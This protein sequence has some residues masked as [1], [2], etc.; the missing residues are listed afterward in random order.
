MNNVII[1]PSLL[2]L[3]YSDVYEDKLRLLITFPDLPEI[4][5]LANKVIL[6]IYDER[7]IY[8]DGLTSLVE[9]G[10]FEISDA[11]SIDKIDITDDNKKLESIFL[12][13]ANAIALKVAQY[14]SVYRD[15]LQDN[16]IRSSDINHWNSS[17]YFNGIAIPSHKSLNSIESFDFEECAN[18]LVSQPLQ[19][20]MLPVN[21][22]AVSLSLKLNN[23][24]LPSIHDRLY[25]NIFSSLFNFGLYRIIQDFETRLIERFYSI[26]N[27]LDQ[28]RYPHFFQL[29][30]NNLD[31][32]VTLINQIIA[33]RSQFSPLRKRLSSFTENDI[34]RARLLK[35]IDE[36]VKRII[37][38]TSD[39]S[40]VKKL[41]LGVTEG[42]G[43]GLKE[44]N[45]FKF[46]FKSLRPLLDPVENFLTSKIN[47]NNIIDIAN[48]ISIAFSV[49][50][51]RALQHLEPI[52]KEQI[53]LNNKCLMLYQSN[54]HR[55][56]E[57]SPRGFE[58]LLIDKEKNKWREY[59]PPK[60][61]VNVFSRLLDNVN[62][63]LNG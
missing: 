25:Y 31:C 38:D 20:S 45:I 7:D 41:A 35:D 55:V 37:C 44:G 19:Y 43:E 13:D 14:P 60:S 54:C 18:L 21:L 52:L 63:L 58:V 39:Y 33:L 12:K 23:I 17:G 40:F 5:I 4:L 42:I 51:P 10:L 30:L 34:N 22:E 57:E 26:T 49:K 15:W 6:P 8:F 47:K 48:M 2:P 1:Y 50:F 46:I 29:I 24:L 28:I 11:N 61:S 9:E 36:A 56:L 27:I 62:Y 3:L 53:L 32:D 16:S 59:N